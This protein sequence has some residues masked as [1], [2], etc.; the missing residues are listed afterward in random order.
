MARGLRLKA[1]A[2]RDAQ[3]SCFRQCRM[4]RI[5]LARFCSIWTAVAA[6]LVAV[7]STSAGEKPRLIVVV[8]VDQLPQE[9]LERMR[10]GF[11]PDG[12]FNTVRDWGAYF[13]SCHHG[14]AN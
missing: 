5:G 1:E 8:S 2:N 9:Y 12:F 4:S 13:R 10:P 11:A 7:P 6:A 3:A 14:Q